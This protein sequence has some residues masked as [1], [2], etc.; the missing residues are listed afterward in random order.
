[1]S[2]NPKYW[3]VIPAAG[4]SQRMG[5]E[6]PKQYQK[7]GDST[8]IEVTLSKFLQHPK[9][10]EII[11]VLHAEDKHWSTLDNLE[12]KNIKTILGGATRAESVFNAVQELSNVASENDF[13]LVHDAARPC[14]S[15]DDLNALINALQHDDVG[16][17]LAAPVSDTIKEVTPDSLKIKQTIDRSVLV[18]ALTPQMFRFGILQKALQHCSK[19]KIHATDEASAIEIMGLNVKIVMGSSGNIKITNMNDLTIA[20]AI[21][22]LVNE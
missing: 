12:L 10:T 19:Q 18:K 14:L 13:V 21:L 22:S 3:V 6:I 9:I 4:I 16:G 8:V 15:K 2:E 11:V 17:I 5:H 20:Q 7:L 1:M